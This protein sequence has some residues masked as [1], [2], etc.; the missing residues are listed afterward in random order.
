MTMGNHGDKCGAD[1]IL[2]AR[3]QSFFLDGFITSTEWESSKQMTWY[4]YTSHYPTSKDAC[5]VY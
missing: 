4:A 3:E 5:L 1:S 2:T